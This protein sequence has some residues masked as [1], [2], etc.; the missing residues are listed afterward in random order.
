MS[1]LLLSTAIVA[2][3]GVMAHA[4]DRQS[5]KNA[6]VIRVLVLEDAQPLPAGPSVTPVVPPVPGSPPVIV[7]AQAIGDASACGNDAKCKKRTSKVFNGSKKQ[8]CEGCGSL[9]YDTWFIFSSCSNFFGEGR[10]APRYPD[11]C[12]GCCPRR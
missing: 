4:E 1:R 11:N 6:K 10:Y 5:A 7:D 2:L 9:R 3:F 8:D 12:P